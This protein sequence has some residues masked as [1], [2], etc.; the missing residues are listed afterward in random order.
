MFDYDDETPSVGLYSPTE[1]IDL[2]SLLPDEITQSGSFDLS[3]IKFSPFGRLLRVLPILTLLLDKSLT[4]RFLNSAWGKINPAYAELEGKPLSSLFSVEK[5]REGVI[6]VA[7]TVLKTR[8][9]VVKESILSY[10]DKK[11]WG[12]L[13]FQ[14]IRCGDERML[15]VLIEDLTQEKR[16]ELLNKKF[17]QELSSRNQL[18]QKEISEKEAVTEALRAS[19]EKYRMI[20]DASPI[21]IIHFDL[22][23]EITACNEMFLRIVGV[24]REAVIGVNL[25][26]DID[27]E[28]LVTAIN[29]AFLGGR[30]SFE[31]DIS[32]PGTDHAVCIKCDFG[33]MFSLDDY[34]IGG[35][36]IIE[37]IADRKRAADLLLQSEKLQAVAELASGV[38]HN[39][40]N[41]LQVVVG[42]AQLAALNIDLGNFK[43][44]LEGLDQILESS[45]FGAETVRRLQ[46]FAKLR[47]KDDETPTHVFDISDTIKQAVD[48]TKPLWK[49]GAERAGV[50]V[51]MRVDA[52]AGCTI[53]G[54]ENEIFEVLVN[55]IKNAVEAMPRGGHINV[56]SSMKGNLIHLSV[57]DEG[58]GIKEED[59][60]KVFTPFWTTKGVQGT[61]I[62]LAS[63]YGT[64]VKHGGQT[65]V[66]NNPSGGALFLITLPFCEDDTTVITGVLGEEFLGGHYTILAIDDVEPILLTLKEGLGLYGHDVLIAQNG[67][68][69]IEKFLQNDI[70]V[71]VCDLAMPGMNGWQVGKAIKELSVSEGRIKPPLILLTGWGGQVKEEKILESGVDL[72]LEKP[73]NVKALLRS[74]NKVISP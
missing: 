62:G 68:V 70:D 54:Y 3:W 35:T 34:I 63:A 44:A 28:G 5:A 24:N 55:L 60:G 45:K 6:S 74:I 57:S 58:L 23:G 37:D 19:E 71:I 22:E 13:S 66:Q 32:I 30:G 72:V 67:A 4:I 11:I 7:T 12:R 47:S 49:T 56:S 43:K 53:R 40:N 14:S 64:V 29:E 2:N 38:A 69:G 50:D 65:S 36:G 1:T 59:L 33:P 16:Q 18:L 9:A 17:Q 52:E 41:L 31:G 39:F 46:D 25:I 26:K 10:E 15:L 20:F 27:E 51:V 73:V 48:M 61:G 21:G 8:K 42:G